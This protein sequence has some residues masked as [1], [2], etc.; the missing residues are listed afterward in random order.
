[1]RLIVNGLTI[2]VTHMASDFVLVTAEEDHPPGEGTLVLKVDGTE[3]RWQVRLPEGISKSS[4]R[5]ALA[6]C[7]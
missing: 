1:M 5:V 6:A 7:E 3:E 2:G 4:K